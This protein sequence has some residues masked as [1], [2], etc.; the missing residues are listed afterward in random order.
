MARKPAD[1]ETPKSDARR[2][3]PRKTAIDALMALVEEQGWRDVELPAVAERAGMK[4]SALRD[5]FPSKGA[6]LAGFARM[7]DH[8][9]IDG[10]NP[11]LMG[12]PAKER[13]FD[14]VMRRLDAMT[15]YKG[16]L[17]ELRKVVRRD[18]AMA[19]ALNQSG[20]NSW[21]YLLG[22]VGIPVEDETGML[23]IQG[24]VLLMA[25]VA[26]VWLDDDDP[27]L[28]KTMSRLDKEL[29]TAGRVLRAA[30]NVRR[31]TAPFMGL[32]RAICERAPR[33][34]RRERWSDRGDDGDR[35]VAV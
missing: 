21:R 6:M 27:A 26:D 23:K 29:E 28:A 11:D 9:V 17:V 4:L 19:A 22:S 7:I 24:S 20:L 33:M 32:A 35:P 12:E 10:A 13:M 34:R 31:I 3:D 2:I 18:A 14:L 25:R 1:S 16:A 8:Q 15:P 5:L 30:E